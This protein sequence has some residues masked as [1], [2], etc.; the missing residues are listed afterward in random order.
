MSKVNFYSFHIFIYSVMILWYNNVFTCQLIVLEAAHNID[1]VKTRLM[2]H[3]GR[4]R[5]VGPTCT[6]LQY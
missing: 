2:K 1:P 4:K 3:G 6:C 5:S